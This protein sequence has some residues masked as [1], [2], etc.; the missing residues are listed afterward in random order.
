M[1]YMASGAGRSQSQT[2]PCCISWI[3]P[4]AINARISR[5]NRTILFACT[6]A[7]IT[8]IYHVSRRVIVPDRIIIHIRVPV[9][10]LDSLRGRNHRIRR[11]ESPQRAVVPARI[12]EVDSQRGLLSLTCKLVVR[13]ERAGGEARLAEGFV[14]R[15]GG[16]DSA[17]VGGHRRTAEMVSEQVGQRPIRADGETRR[18]REVILGDGASA[19]LL[20]VVADEVSGHAVDGLRDAVAVPIMLAC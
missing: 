20:V 7:S 16:L 18:A 3:T 15:G 2:I 5:R 17:G 19:C 13:A 14:Q 4:S 9:P 6:T 1:S 8:L 12:E 10:R 11:K